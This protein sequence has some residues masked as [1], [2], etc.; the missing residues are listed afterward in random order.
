MD[1][2]PLKR[3]AYLKSISRDHHHGL[4]FCWKIREGFKRGVAADRIKQYADWFWRA[5]LIDHFALEERY[6]FPVLGDGHELVKR[7]LAEHRRLK[8]LF[9][10]ETEVWRS[11]SL[12]EEELDEHI[13]FEERVLFS[14]LQRVATTPQLAEIAEHH[15][16]AAHAPEWG[17]EFWKD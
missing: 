16:G 5:H 12:I 1:N 2:K 13:R 4:L 8:R 14:E 15:G 3:S 7:A 10:Q 11:L 6:I 9:E 17:D